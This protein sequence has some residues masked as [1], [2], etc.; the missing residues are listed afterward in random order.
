MADEQLSMPLCCGIDIQDLSIATLQKHLSNGKFTGADLVSCYLERI[1]RL[2]RRLKAVI[3]VNPDAVDIASRLDSERRAGTLRGPLHGIPFLVKDNMATH[4]KMQ[5]TAGSSVLIGTV[6]AEDAAVVS[7]LREAGAV[8]LGHANMSEWAAMRSSYYSEGY[9]SRGGQGRNPYNLAEH[10]GGTSSGS[11]TA[12]TTNMC[13]FSL[14]TETDG[15]VIFP[16]DRNGIVGIK[17]T[18]GSTS[19]RGVIPESRHLDVV[20]TLG[21]TTYDAA[22]ALSAI[23]E[24]EDQHKTAPSIESFVCTKSALQGARF[25]MPWKRVWGTVFENAKKAH[26]S[27]VLKDVI[28]KIRAAGSEVVENAGFPS[29]ETIIPP[30]GWDWDYPSTLGHPEQSEFTVV[31]IDFYNDVKNYLSTLSAN[32]FN[33]VGLEDIV[34]Y[35]KKHADE[36]GGL[37]SRHGAWPTGQDNFER[38]LKFR[39]I[40][41]DTY[42]EALAF[43]RK[44]SRQEGIDAALQTGGTRLDGLLV[45]I[46]ADSGVA[47]QVAAKAGYPMITIPVGTDVDGVPFGIGIIQT[48]GQ[49]TLLVKYGSAI[50]DL[51]QAR[52]N[53]EFRNFD[54]DNYM[55]V[56]V[57]P[58]ETCSTLPPGADSATRSAEI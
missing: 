10:P 33:I 38:V 52:T 43:I 53:P 18:L 57:D 5:T 9:S 3:E 22:V 39:G 8:L 17:P 51:L 32:P 24:S 41:D 29:A 48:A 49:E 30:D 2:N 37:P 23:L 25:G 55:Y 20:G 4:D 14:G 27:R 15:S 26:Q 6:V 21:K 13:A 19:C 28:S 16:A 34:S 45:P 12:V 1:R 56:G 42:K 58:S 35:N 44:K 47:C 50:E 46:Q 31:K 11:A 54:A 40:E 7:K 36:E